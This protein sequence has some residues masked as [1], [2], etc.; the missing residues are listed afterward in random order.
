MRDQFIK[1]GVKLTKLPDDKLLNQAI[2]SITAKAMAKATEAGFDA[3]AI[4]ARIKD[5]LR[6]Y[7]DQK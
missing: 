5:T 7:E 3:G 4:L 2:D 1:A 6:K